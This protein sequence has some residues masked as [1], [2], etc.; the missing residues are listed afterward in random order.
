MVKKMCKKEKERISKST[1]LEAIL[2]ISCVVLGLSCI[3]LGAGLGPSLG[4]SWLVFGLVLAHLG[5]WKAVTPGG[6]PKMGPES[7]ILPIFLR[8]L[9]LILL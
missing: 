2:G 5:S 3:I 7:H 9:T 6:D 8:G 4:L 1:L